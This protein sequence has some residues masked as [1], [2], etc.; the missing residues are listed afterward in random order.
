VTSFFSR[1]LEQPP[2]TRARVQWAYVV[3]MATDLIQLILVPFGWAFVDEALDIVA[4][5]LVSRALGFHVMLLPTFALE[6]LPFTDMLPTWTGCVALVI[7]L[8]KRQQAA[9]PRPPSN[10]CPYATS[11][12]TQR[13]PKRSSGMRPNTGEAAPAG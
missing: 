3:A 12:S 8:R 4:M 10:G 1:L 5:I 9:I 11:G 6:F 2:L 7:A 13:S